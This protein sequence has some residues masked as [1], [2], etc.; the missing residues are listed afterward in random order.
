[1]FAAMGV[2]SSV[3]AQALPSWLKDK[4]RI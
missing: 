3:K 1:M 2:V 4:N